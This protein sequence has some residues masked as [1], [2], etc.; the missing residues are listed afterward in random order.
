VQPFLFQ[1]PGVA[2]RVPAY[3]FFIAV[4]FLLG[5]AFLLREVQRQAPDRFE[6]VAGSFPWIILSSLVGSRLFFA[7][8]ERPAEFV[9]NPLAI[10]AV[11]QGGHVYY[12]GLIGAVLACIWYCRRNGMAFL[13]F[14][15]LA[16]C[17]VAL[18]QITARIGCFLAGCCWGKPTAVPWAVTFTHPESLCGL[19]GVPVHPAQLYQALANLLT[20]A[21]CVY[22]LRRKQFDGQV[23][24]WYAIAYPVGRFIVEIF[25]DSTGRA[26]VVPGLLSLAQL[27]SLLILI[28]ATI[29]LIRMRVSSRLSHKISCASR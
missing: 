28:V 13:W 24:L 4:S 5:Y 12:G 22:V 11:A 18:G 20:F 10:F 15:D 25:R 6:T 16:I 2:I 3:G 1:V 19:R 27:V 17:G 23:F 8:F 14:A 21:V 26:F 29:M 7:V 9:R